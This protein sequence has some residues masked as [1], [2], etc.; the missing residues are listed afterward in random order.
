MR[1]GGL[2]VVLRLVP[3]SV[4]GVF[5]LWERFVLY[6]EAGSAL[7]HSLGFCCAVFYV[8]MY[9]SGRVGRVQAILMCE[10]SFSSS[11][12]IFNIWRGW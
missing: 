5:E 2:Y 9:T 3:Y 7:L 4:V 11:S 6:V 12:R 8:F 1:Q 10:L